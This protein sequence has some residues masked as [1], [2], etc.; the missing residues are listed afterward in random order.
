MLPSLST[1]LFVYSQLSR[2]ILTL[3]QENG[4]RNIELWGMPPHFPLG[5][6]PDTKSLIEI[7]DDLGITIQSVHGPFYRSVSHALAG[8]WL[9]LCDPAPQK[10][11][12]AYDLILLAIEAMNILR[13]RILVVHS[14]LP[15][16][17][18]RKGKDLLQENL[19]KLA[20]LAEKNG[21]MLALENG[22]ES[23][24]GVSTT[25]AVVEELHSPALGICLDIGH[26]NVEPGMD[27]LKAIQIAGPHLLNLHI[28]D[29]YG[30]ADEHNVPGTGTIQWDQIIKQVTKIQPVRLR[31][32]SLLFTYELIDPGRGYPRDFERFLPVL[33]EISNFSNHYL[34]K[35]V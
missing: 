14:G 10:R 17:K 2:D 23:S 26:A 33:S 9:S 13:S 25:A 21:I 12:E 22:P 19:I 3:I 30:L 24:S 1:H 11:R 34:G 18:K 35:K 31:Q 8:E 28:S 4:F 20:T 27:P 15:E 7:L 32:E 5:N 29:N 6:I 16:K